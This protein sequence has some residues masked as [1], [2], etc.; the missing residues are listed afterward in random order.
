L[1]K[2]GLAAAQ[3]VID[4]LLDALNMAAASQDFRVTFSVGVAVF[5]APPASEDVVLSLADRL[6]YRAKTEGKNRVVYETAG[7][8][9]AD[10]APQPHTAAGAA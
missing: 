3:A 4:Q 6:M 10:A 5:E 2:T 1:P 7:I 9:H 8:P